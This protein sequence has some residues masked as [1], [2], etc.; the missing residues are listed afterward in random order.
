[1]YAARILHWLSF[2]ARPLLLEEIAEAAAIDPEREAPFNRDEIIEDPLEVLDICS[3]L[4]TLTTIPSHK[5]SGYDE[6]LSGYYETR[7]RDC[8]AVILAHY[9]VQEYLSSDRCLHGPMARYGAIPT[10]CHGFIATSCLGYLQ[11]LNE[12]DYFFTHKI[13]DVKL[14]VYSARYWIHHA[15]RAS[16]DECVTQHA[17]ALMSKSNAAIGSGCTTRTNLGKIRI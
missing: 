3:S 9:S 7:P 11:H 10:A 2:S 16:T 1:M 5:L 13:K 6:T 12:E 4:L 15:R 8:Q 17:V 14:G